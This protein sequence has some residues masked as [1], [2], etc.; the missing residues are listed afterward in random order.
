MNRDCRPTR[1]AFTLVELLVVLAIIGMLVGLILPAVQAAREAGRSTQCK[2]NLRQIALATSLF[3]DAH[4]AFPPA[5]YQPRPGDS[6][7]YACGGAEATW[8]VRILP[9]LEHAAAESQWDYTMPYAS[10]SDAIRSHA[11]SV[12]ACPTRR[13]TGSVGAGLLTGE[14]T[15]WITL[16]CGCRVP[17]RTSSS[18]LASGAVGD[19]AGNHGDL[20]P[21]AVGLPSD[22]YYGGNGSG[23]I[24]SSRAHCR[25]TMPMDWADRIRATDILDGLSNTA[26]TGEMHVPLGKLGESGLDAFIFNGD[27]VFN[28]T[29]VGGPTVPIV[30]NMRDE[31]NGLAAWGSWHPGICHFAM[32]DGSLRAIA[33]TID[34]ELLGN[35]CSRNDGQ[36]TAG[37]E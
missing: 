3:H 25:A 20:S 16:P 8:L 10:H 14:T 5:R 36:I 28:S 32:S 34:T 24:I 1:T 6:S 19:Y 9:F 26:L 11:P 12:Y 13:A 29:R 33:S 18:T 17:V 23:V 31:R 2:N 27:H 35:L 22:F 15:Q 21:G 30:T 37:H 7:A 4:N